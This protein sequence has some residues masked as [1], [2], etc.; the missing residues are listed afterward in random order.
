[1][2]E[3]W[4]FLDSIAST[5]SYLSRLAQQHLGVEGMTV[6]ADY[7]EAGKGQGTH[8]WYSAKGE[9][10]L[11]STLLFP[12]FLSAS[13][14]FQLSRVAS[15]AICD[16][17]EE[18]KI[19]PLIKWPNDILVDRKKIAGILIEHTI[20]GRH[21]SYSILGMG[22]NLNQTTFPEF[23]LQATSV[24]LA[25]QIQTMPREV[26]KR[27]RGHLVTRYEELRNGNGTGLEEAYLDKL[28]MFRQ[29]ARFHAGGISFDG[30]IEGLSEQGEL[31]VEQDGKL[32]TFGYGE[33]VLEMV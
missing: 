27:L 26:A 28:F 13:H 29:R 30:T 11:M 23:P 5:N 31:Q 7:Q 21:I 2:K 17:L 12:V 18:M 4:I 19:D 32:R 20:T 22:L 25:A 9:N 15:L 24:K 14:Q 10:L 6:L 16:V 3:K 1:M 33:I 8:G